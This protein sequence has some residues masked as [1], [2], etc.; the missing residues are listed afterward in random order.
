[1]NPACHDGN[2]KKHFKTGSVN[3]LLQFVQSHLLLQL[4]MIFFLLS[5]P[6]WSV[7]QTFLHEFGKCSNE[8]FELK[9]YDK[10]PNADAV[11][12]YDI[13]KSYF[14][15]SGG[16]FNVV[17]ERKLKLK[18]FNKAGIKHANFD[19]PY[20]TGKNGDESV[21]ELQGNVYNYENG[22]VRVSHLDTE[23]DY[24][25][26]QNEHWKIKK[27]AMPDVKEGS[28]VE[29]AYTITS[30]YVFNFRNWEFQSHIPVIYSE[31][32]TKMIP[33]Y[34][35][36]YIL[37]GMPRFD[38]FKNYQSE[39]SEYSFAGVKYHEMI[40]DFVM[41]DLPGFKDESFITSE[42]DYIVKM[43]FQLSAMHY[44][45]GRVE[46]IMR[47]WPELSK[48]L[49]DNDYFGR[50]INAA[51]KKA[52][53]I[54]L[55]LNLSAL[56]KKDKAK[57]IFEYVISNYSWNK[58]VS[59]FVDKSVKDF[60]LSKTGNSASIN[61]FMLAML[62]E[63]GIEADPVVLSTRNHGKIKMDYPFEYFF[64]DVVAYAKLDSG[65]V[66]MDATEPLCTFNQIPT[67]CLNDRGLVVQKNKVE[68][69]PLKGTT[70][71]KEEYQLEIKLN[72]SLD[73]VRQSCK[74]IST[75]YDAV[76]YRDTYQSEKDKLKKKLLG[77][78]ALETE[79]LEA[80]NLT[81]PEKPFLLRYEK[82]NAIDVVDGKLIIEPFGNTVMSEN[83]LKQQLRS[84]PVDMTYQKT[85]K[86]YARIMVPAGYKLLSKPED[87]SINNGLVRVIY[88]AS[89][90]DDQTVQIVASYEF[91][92]D[93]Y[94]S[95]DYSNLKAY[96]NMIVSK[97]NDK[98]VLSKI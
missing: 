66:V 58:E 42:Q 65:T 40:Y 61:L 19:I 89:A 7:G 60:S 95:E 39:G 44:P 62:N 26:K 22:S 13:G 63:A 32:I 81:Q 50:Y 92:K 33:F 49:L 17:F 53:D 73:S 36:T 25:E 90:M 30:P 18:I 80:D 10:A 23:K 86:F 47:T 54:L 57:I 93:V 85:N 52:K 6:K 45:D 3:G 16:G 9:K 87:M 98:I 29:L 46:K 70:P 41:K 84:Y 97:F 20:Y 51:R 72:S 91:K 76:Y 96:I 35:Y 68:W 27:I 56:T 64:N 71:S 2:K 28:V 11:V 1:M 75:G 59:K 21:S 43:D 74:L 94:P 55:P 24:N 15:E 34:E 12:I 37:Q 88:T 38:D 14:S 79:K 31:Y 82:N 77:S 5:I 67:R 69:I 48:E 78:N 83:P 8:D 4:G